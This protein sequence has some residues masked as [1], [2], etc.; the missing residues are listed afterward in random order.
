MLLRLVLITGFVLAPAALLADE[1]Q[2]ATWHE[3]R[4]DH[5]IIRTDDERERAVQLA[6]DLEKYRFT[7]AYLSGL[8]TRE[9]A[10]V[11]VTVFA[12]AKNDDYLDVTKAYGTG[13]F[14]NARPAGPV[15]VLSL[16]DGEEEWELGGK[17]VLF[18]EYTHHILHQFSPISY[19]RWYDEGFAEFM[20]TM[21]FEGD[22]ALIGKPAL[23]RVPA[24]KRV[25]DWVRTFEIL[26]SRGRYMGRIGTN[27]MR[28]PRRAKSG[29][30][31]QYA[32]GW[33]MVHYLH[34]NAR[35]Q[36]GVARYLT[37][38]NRAGISDEKAFREAFGIDYRQFDRQLRDYWDSA[39][40]ATG[41]VEIAS[42]LPPI[43]PVVREMSAEEVKAVPYEVNVLAGRFGLVAADS[44]QSAFQDCIDEGIR[45][46]DMRLAAIE[47]AL[48]EENWDRAQAVI[49][50]LTEHEGEIAPALIARVR[51]ERQKAEDELE[52]EKA[53]QLR[54]VAKQAIFDEPTY[55]PAL[56]Q[57]ADLTFEHDLPVDD[58]VRSV[59]DSIRFLAPDIE[60]GKI[61]EARW[62]AEKGAHDQAEAVIDE[63]IKWSFSPEQANQLRDLK[64]ELSE[65]R[66]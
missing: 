3:I 23:H 33:L 8:Q 32:Q 53:R 16:E 52:A 31:L 60:E 24:L 9:V 37:A 45:P 18:H 1:D 56:I 48:A 42:K 63:M 51:L 11:P 34:S 20:A 47:L 28:D 10:S 54:A 50:N 58:Q 43:E 13:G 7:V 36:Q 19:P 35:L 15:S 46:V 2:A 6:I 30:M 66:S 5:F 61:F 65:D 41:K 55:V 26:D 25:S 38:I 4:T 17:G 21:E 39:K 14:Y 59:I 57:F 44:A 49:D 22:Y 12:F 29:I 62:L 64:K 27:L 40:L